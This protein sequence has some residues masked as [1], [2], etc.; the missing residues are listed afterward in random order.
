MKRATPGRS[1]CAPTAQSLGGSNLLYAV[2]NAYPLYPVDAGSGRGGALG[3]VAGNVSISQS[4]LTGNTAQG[5]SLATDVLNGITVIL[6]GS[7]GFGGGVDDEFDFG[8]APPQQ[9]TALS[10]VG[11]TIKSNAALGSGP[12]GAGNGGGVASAQVNASVTDSIV[13]GNHATGSFSGGRSGTTSGISGIFSFPLGGGS[14]SG[15]GLYCPS[16]ALTISTSAVDDNLAQGGPAETT[17]GG[18]ADGGGVASGAPLVLSNVTLAGNQ[19]KGGASTGSNSIGGGGGG[20][21]GTPI[22]LETAPSPVAGPG[23]AGSA[24]R[25]ACP[26]TFARCSRARRPRSP[27][28]ISSRNAAPSSLR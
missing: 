18:G 4:T 25:A 17:F 2:S 9:A 26:L 11:T 6:Q 13:D 20:G 12:S 14:A 27:I 21:G 15:G 8:F 19:A 24:M 3:A 1:V 7:T 16:G 28:A 5:G 22:S 10:I 23:A